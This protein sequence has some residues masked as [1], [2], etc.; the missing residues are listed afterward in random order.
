MSSNS[1]V[2]TAQAILQQIRDKGV[3]FG[4]IFET[5]DVAATAQDSEAQALYDT[6]MKD[7]LPWAFKVVQRELCTEILHLSQQ[8][9]G[10]HFNNV[11]ATAN[12][13]DGSFMR[14]A[15]MRM[16]KE[17]PLLWKLIKGL[18]DSNPK[19][20]RVGTEDG[21]ES[22]AEQEALGRIGDLEEG[23][24]GDIGGEDGQMDIDSAE[25]SEE[26]NDKMQ[27]DEVPDVDE[28]G[29]SSK[30]SDGKNKKKLKRQQRAMRR[31]A[32]LHVIKSVV[33]ISIFLQ[34]SNERCNYLQSVLGLFYHSAAVP[35]KVIEVL[36]HAGLSISLSSI[37]RSVKSL[38]AEAT[39]RIRNSVQTLTTAF[40]YDNF[41]IHFKTSQP[42]V[43]HST[44]FISA[45]SAT[46]IPLFNV[47][48]PSALRCSRE[49]WEKDPLN[50]APLLTPVQVDLN[51]MLRFHKESEA[52]KPPDE[53]T[54]LNPFLERYAWHIR[55]IL[56]Q[57]GPRDLKKR[58]ATKLGE[59]DPINQI[60][61]HKTEQIPCRAMNIKESTPD[62]NVEVMEC[63]LNQG[64]IGDPHDDSF[65]SQGDVD[66]S[67]SVL[68]VHGD[69]LTKE[70]L[71]SVRTSRAIEETPKRRFQ[72]AI[73]VPGLF[74]FKMACVDAL[75]RTWIQPTA[76]R[77][78]PNSLYQHVGILRPKETGKVGTNPGFRRMHDIIH[79]DLWASMLDCWKLEAASRNP[80]WTTLDEFMKSEPSWQLI[81]DMSR[82]IVKKYVGTTPDVSKE[83]RKPSDERDDIF[84]NQILR[85][86]NELLYIE[87]SHAMNAGDIGRVEETF[88][89]WIYI[90]RATG[91][92]KYAAQML[93]FMINLRDVY[94]PELSRIIRWNWLCNP[95]GKLKAF[96]GVDWLN[97]VIYGGSGSNR[98]MEHIIEESILIELFRECHVTVEKG[99][100][101]VNCTITHHPPNM[102]RT[103]RRLARQF[104]EVSPHEFKPGR[105]A[106]YQVPDKIAQGM[107][108][109]QT[110]KRIDPT[111]DDN[112]DGSAEVE[113]EDLFDD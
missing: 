79:H 12:F 8:C 15:A 35:E 4:S 6:L 25:E 46:A 54:K 49:L 72:F 23:D 50:P 43:E 11:K 38:S 37:H 104:E 105:R 18:L 75:W 84:A 41:D 99:F 69:L 39:K 34:S 77:T 60:P 98:T 30:E 110:A 62:G 106:D 29:I 73:F 5:L 70:R 40:A 66:M 92:H 91:K 52:A 67:E 103:L 28:N 45:T 74:H 113:A 44:S 82:N 109:I 93:R 112:V 31:R 89:Q 64:G 26:E 78:D 1:T 108:E 17:A 13:L 86:Y 32:S 57:H 58:F 48:D 2:H 97:Q 111:T 55:D 19:S 9:H 100:H 10:F 36:A 107:H 7:A 102:E 80:K 83:R 63:L 16:N 21:E 88:L 56:L 95:T 81:E 61:V 20:R 3:T 85:N 47:V 68:L 59:P 51:D 24:L 33:C 65:D 94:P 22:I 42:T 76:A 71:D 101:L 14:E 27:V 87:T 53:P 96:R 90:F